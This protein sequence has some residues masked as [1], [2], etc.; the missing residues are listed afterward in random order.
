MNQPAQATPTVETTDPTE[1]GKIRIL[2][3]AVRFYPFMGGMETHV[4]EVTRRLARMGAD[5]TVLTLNPEGKLPAHE[6]LEGVHIRRVQAWPNKRDFSIAPDIYRI[7]NQ[8]NWDVVHAQGYHTLVPPLAMLAARRAKVPYV[9]SFHSGGHSSGLRNAS[10][11]IQWRVLQ[12]LLARAQRLVA[13]SRFEADFFAKQLG[14]TPQQFVV[15]PNGSQLPELSEALAPADPAQKLIVSVGRL[16]KYKGHHRVL[17][18]LPLVL[19]RYP[20]TRLH[21]VGSGPYEAN[22]WALAKELRVADRVKIEPIPPQDREGMARLLSQASLMTLLSEYEA[23]P[24]SVTEA[25]ARHCPVLVA[26]TS[27]LHE[28]AERN[29]ARAVPLES[30]PDIIAAAIMNQFEHPLVATDVKLPTWEDCATELL[31]LYSTIT[32]ES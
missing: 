30:T 1:A 29:E 11:V 3:V 26:D 25:L 32:K 16:E 31:T 5:V 13:V 20:Q 21:I 15:I 22:L 6:D 24:I 28:F 8:E 10:R 7:I 18:A 12:P 14:I 23:H 27:G 2:M 9:L 19:E 4:Y 17:Q